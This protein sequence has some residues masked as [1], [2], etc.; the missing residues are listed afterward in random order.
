MLVPKAKKGDVVYGVEWGTFPGWV[1]SFKSETVCII[2]G[3]IT[4][5]GK[6]FSCGKHCGF[7]YHL[8]GSDFGILEQNCSLTWGDVPRV[9]SQ[10]D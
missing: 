10:Y 7:A 2:K 3:K 5:I 6:T 1:H 9:V 8:D 4:R